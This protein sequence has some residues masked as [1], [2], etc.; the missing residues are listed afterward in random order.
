[1]HG[2][3]LGTQACCKSDYS[4]LS[5]V[6]V[7]GLHP[8]PRTHLD[9]E[10]AVQGLAN[11]VSG[12][13][14][15]PPVSGAVLRSTANVTVGATSRWSI[16]LQGALK[17][18]ALTRSGVVLRH[19]PTA[20]L[21]AFFAYLGW[22]LLRVEHAVFFWCKGTWSL[23]AAALLGGVVANLLV[24]VLCG[25]VVIGLLLCAAVR[26]LRGIVQGDQPLWRVHFEGVASFLSHLFD[27]KVCVRTK[28]SSQSIPSLSI[29]NRTPGVLCVR[30]LPIF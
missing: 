15:G 22:A 20:G 19:L 25:I 9:R 29:K 24:G 2:P 3:I 23:Y 21:A 13:L 8:G 28:C 26:R 17:L 18:L 6:A 30:R 12:A 10:L 27:M 1:M 11:V 5:A 14:G 4:L 16:T 7:D